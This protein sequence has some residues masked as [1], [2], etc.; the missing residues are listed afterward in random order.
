MNKALVDAQ[1]ALADFLEL[2]PEMWEKQREIDK[3]LATTLDPRVRMEIL[4]VELQACNDHLCR[5]LT[6]ILPLVLQGSKK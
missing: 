6:E 2:H 5:E 3:L 4:A 1:N